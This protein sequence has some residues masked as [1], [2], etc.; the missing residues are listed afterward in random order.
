MHDP[1]GSQTHGQPPYGYRGER[2]HFVAAVKA[3]AHPYGTDGKIKGVERS[4]GMADGA[5]NEL[6]PKCRDSRK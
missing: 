6:E 3:A 1:T 2:L 4:L 5:K